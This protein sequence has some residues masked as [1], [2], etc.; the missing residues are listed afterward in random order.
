MAEE[1]QKKA[2]KGIWQL[3]DVKGDTLTRKNTFSPKAGKGY[4][5]AKHK[6]RATC[7]HSGYTEF[8]SADKSKT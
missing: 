5:M 6:D 4:F 7:G 3:Y 2:A 1:P 8:A